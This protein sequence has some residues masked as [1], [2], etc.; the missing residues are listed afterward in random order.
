MERSYNSGIEEMSDEESI[1]STVESGSDLEQPT[2][3][4]SRKLP[5]R[6]RA[7]VADTEEHLEA[8]MKN[9][10]LAGELFLVQPTCVC[11]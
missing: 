5:A 8:K 6:F 1:C 3:K 11:I 2:T 4:R 10:K 9:S 7:F